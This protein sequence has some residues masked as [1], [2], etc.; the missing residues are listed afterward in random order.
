MNR[1]QIGAVAVI[2]CIAVA[3]LY[4]IQFRKTVEVGDTVLVNYTAYLDTGEIIDTSFEEVAQ[5]ETQ[6]KVWWFRLRASYEPLQ[7]EVGQGAL[8]PDFEMALIGMHEGQKK[9]ITIPPERAYGFSDSNKIVEFALV[10]KLKKEEEVPKTEFTERMMKEPVEG[11]QY[12]FQGFIITV[13]EVSEENVTFSYELEVGQEIYIGL[14]NAVVTSETDTEYEITL[15]PE[16]GDMI[17]YSYYG[18][19]TIIEITEEAMV[20]DFNSPLAGETL[21]YTIW[22]VE[23]QKN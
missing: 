18:Q 9:E 20:V 7:V 4:F 13:N 6:P 23:I 14:G 22:I 11:E 5:D 12:Q 8:L 15:N 3:G 21:H 2:V 16:L 17:T 1:I 19:G 10:R